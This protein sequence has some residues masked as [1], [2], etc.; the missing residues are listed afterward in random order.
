MSQQQ[1]FVPS[2]II[3]THGN[4]SQDVFIRHEE[5]GHGGFATVY[6]VTHKSTNKVYAMKVISKEHANSKG[7]SA[8]EKLKSEMK[9]QKSLN[10]PNIV[11]SKLSFSDESNFYIVLE[12]CPGKSIRELLRKSE[13]GYLSEPETRKILR[14][15]IKGLTFLH[16]RQ[17]IHHDIKLENFLI[18]ANGKVKIA[19]FGLSTVLKEDDEKQ[20]SICGTTS[21]L[22][23]EIINKEGHSFE[24]DVWAIGVSAFIML[25]GQSPFGVGKKETIYENIKN[26][27]YEFP[28]RIPLSY[29]AKS[30]IKSILKI[31]PHRR[32]TAANLSKHQFMT[33]IDTIP[34]CLYRPI[35][36]P[37]KVLS[38]NLTPSFQKVDSFNPTHSFQKMQPVQP[39]HSF[40]K[41][42]INQND[43]FSPSKF[44]PIMIIPNNNIPTSIQT[45]NIFPT[46]IQPC[47]FLTTTQ[48]KRNIYSSSFRS[49]SANNHLYKSPISDDFDKSIKSVNN[50][51]NYVSNEFVSKI[52]NPGIETYSNNNNNNN[53]NNNIKVTNNNFT[54]PSYFV[55]KYCIH[56]EDMGYLLGD[57]TVGVCFKNQSRMVLDP[58]EEF[59]QYYKNYDSVAESI[60]I[61]D[62]FSKR[63]E[64]SAG[65]EKLQ[66]KISLVIRF[67]KSLK[68]DKSLF[69]T[70]STDYDPN[71]PLH[72]VKYY[73]SK[74]N[75][76]LF[77]LND[78]NIQVNFNDHKKLIIFWS[79]KKMCLVRCMKDKCKLLDLK[80]VAKMNTNCDE[81]KKFKN[82]KT[83]LS[84]LA[85]KI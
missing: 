21:Y 80:E 37:Q 39:T 56:K 51:S 46:P 28:S 60:N 78:K 3:Y 19:D 77:K 34:V 82:A 4:G 1:I 53:I 31:D 59:V 58:N 65:K 71:V 70:I 13:N 81:L 45:N 79:T 40:Q 16:N 66:S 7:R 63:K 18:G 49:A 75:S 50:I 22:S 17:I 27:D 38:V 2:T 12:Y 57:G 25:T 36:S 62:F 68:V 54:I 29:E 47:N 8:M 43:M 84:I 5:I 20:F 64:K 35:Q 67:A 32:P 6:R 83:M 14:D 55:A 52:Q 74:D 72:Y 11:R 26:C 41:S 33:K 61:L 9:I 85:K 44:F 30:F 15:I 23:P 69:E 24:V 42:T 48:P 76:I 73:V 10:H